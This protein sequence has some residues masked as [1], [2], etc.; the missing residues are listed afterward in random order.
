MQSN[1]R[2]ASNLHNSNQPF[3]HEDNQDYLLYISLLILGIIHFNQIEQ[4]FN[5]LHLWLLLAYDLSLLGLQTSYMQS[6]LMSC[7]RREEDKSDRGISWSLFLLHI[8]THFVTQL[9]TLSTVINLFSFSLI[10]HLFVSNLFPSWIIQLE[11]L[12][13]RFQDQ[14]INRSV[15][16]YTYAISIWHRW[17][18]NKKLIW[19]VVS[20]MT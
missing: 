8:L 5:F 3:N 16:H 2:F 11:T 4:W 9:S 19:W 12:R 6:P 7:L 17:Q 13:G 15:M 1:M 10:S 20:C 18:T 14:Y